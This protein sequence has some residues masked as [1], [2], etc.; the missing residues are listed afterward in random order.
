MLYPSILLLNHPLILKDCTVYLTGMNTKTIARL[1]VGLVIIGVTVFF[2][3][4]GAI[5]G[6]VGL[7]VIVAV[8]LAYGVIKFGGPLKRLLGRSR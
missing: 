8:G 7:V 6:Q 2:V 3:Q 5:T 1:I 4:Q